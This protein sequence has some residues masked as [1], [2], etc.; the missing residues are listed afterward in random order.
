MGK[1]ALIGQPY[2]RDPELRQAYAADIAPRTEVALSKILRELFGG[3]AAGTPPRVL[4][5]GAGTGAAGRAI[6]LFFGADTELVSV[7]RVA[8]AGMV[9]ADVGA[10]GPLRGVDGR[11]DLIVA[12]HLLN[13]L[14]VTLPAAARIAARVQRVRA[15]CETLLAPGGTMVILE[16]ALRETS[17]DL[18]ARARPAGRRRHARR[19]PLLVGRALPRARART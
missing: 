16:P 12:A 19:R 17:R 5:L 4:D 11:F 18:L 14:F 3:A 1:R 7:D 15:W 6:R 2:L 13:E 10:P 9:V 8:A